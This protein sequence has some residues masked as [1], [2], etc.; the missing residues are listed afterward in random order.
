[1]IFDIRYIDDGD[2]DF[3]LKLKMMKKVKITL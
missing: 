3:V 1:M 2:D